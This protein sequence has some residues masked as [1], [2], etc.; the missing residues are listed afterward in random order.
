M[1]RQEWTPGQ[2]L[3][4]AVA[5]VWATYYDEAPVVDEERIWQVVASTLEPKEALVLELR[6][7]RSL[8]YSLTLRAIGAVLKRGQDTGI[9]VTGERARAIE[10]KAL[11]KLRHPTRF[12]LLLEATSPDTRKKSEK[13]VEIGEQGLRE[14]GFHI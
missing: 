7:G 5:P 14:R 4:T 8:G 1:E 13:V 6:F 11:R 10:A 9:G 2:Q 12:V 3:F